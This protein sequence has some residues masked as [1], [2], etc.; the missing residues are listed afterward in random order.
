MTQ[1]RS[2]LS[3]GIRVI[4]QPWVWV[5]ALTLVGFLLRRYHLGTES[6]WFD[7]ADLVRRAQQPF[8]TLIKGFTEAG[9]NG[10]LYTVLLHFWLEAL[11]T[12]PLLEKAAHLAF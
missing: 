11:R 2:R 12:V 9:E 6:L 5:A 1:R 10:P 3:Y 8:S 7:E 4:A